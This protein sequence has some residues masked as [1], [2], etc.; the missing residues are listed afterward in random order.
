[1]AAFVTFVKTYAVFIYLFL[2]LGILFG[3][4]MLMDAQRLSRATLFS[5]DQERATQ[6]TYSALVVMTV[7]L[8]GMF[9]TTGIVVFVAPLAPT[10][11]PAI[12]R[13]PTP[14]LAAYIFPTNTRAPTASPTLPPSTE[15]PFA[16]ATPIL[17]TAT[18]TVIKPTNVPVAAATATP[19]FGMPAPIIVGPLP[20]GGTWIGEGQANAA[21]TFRWNCDPCA[22]GSND[23]YEVVISFIDKSGASRTYAGRTQDKFIALRRIYEG[24]GFELY[25]KAKEDT[26]Q[27]YVVVKREPG[28]QPLSPPSD[29]WKFVWH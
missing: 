15:T 6:Q 2:V 19:I 21:M 23:W 20:N 16:T 1:M 4:K 10:Q 12:L 25:Q 3:I 22:L 29:T 18:H 24:G 5:L 9:I 11:D 17:A 28:N 14:T 7:F 27:W 26:Y 13:G 8:I